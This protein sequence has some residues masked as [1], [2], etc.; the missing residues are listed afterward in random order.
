MPAVAV[1]EAGS[2]EGFY[3]V[4]SLPRVCGFV[5]CWVSGISLRREVSHSREQ[6]MRRQEPP[7][8]GARRWFLSSW[9]LGS[10]L[11]EPQST[12]EPAPGG[13][14]T[15][16]D[17][18]VIILSESPPR[19]CKDRLGRGESSQAPKGTFSLFRRQRSGCE[20]QAL[21]GKPQLR[22]VGSCQSD[23]EGTCGGKQSL[24]SGL[25]GRGGKDRER[26]RHRHRER[27]GVR[28]REGKRERKRKA[29]KEYAKGML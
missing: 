1:Q 17:L 15:K 13:T 22:G 7:G 8:G 25:G 5:N 9:S 28:E 16:R 27:N 18:S 4:P 24:G 14:V 10:D 11:P 2:R 3:L 29:E 12:C 20:P 23:T 19:V 6:L 26:E 21:P